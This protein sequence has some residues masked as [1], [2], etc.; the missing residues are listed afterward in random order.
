MPRQDGSGSGPGHRG[1]CW[2]SL[3]VSKASSCTRALSTAGFGSLPQKEIQGVDCP[4]QL[5]VADP[6]AV[7]TS[8]L[9]GMVLSFCQDLLV[10]DEWSCQVTADNVLSA[11]EAPACC[12]NLSACNMCLPGP[13]SM[14]HDPAVS[15][16]KYK[17]L[18]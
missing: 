8:R 4:S 14:D 3:A 12:D 18:P 1:A 15:N 9:G 17:C 7:H 16:G 11:H 13:L 2:G 10:P 5:W 6:G